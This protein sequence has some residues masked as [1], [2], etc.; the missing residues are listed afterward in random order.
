MRNKGFF[1]FISVLLVSVCL[2]QLSFT[3][4][5]S[6]VEAAAE[7]K[8]DQKVRALRKEAAKN[9]GIAYLSNNT[10]IDFKEADGADLAK[11]AYLNEILRDK[12]EKE[13][14]PV[15]GSTFSQV[16]KRSL[17]FGLDLVGGMSV[18][19]EISLPD[20][21][22]NYAKNPRDLKFR[23]PFEAALRL[24]KEDFLDAFIQEYK[25]INKGLPLNYVFKGEGIGIRSTDA[26]VES[27]FRTLISSS[28]DGVEQIMSRRINQFGVAQPNIQKDGA[29]NRLYIELPGVQDENTVAQKL[30]STAN[31][32]FFETYA[33]SELKLELEKADA[34]SKKVEDQVTEDTT[35]TD[36]VQVESL[37]DTKN[38][39]K[40]G[41]TDLIQPVGDFSIGA[42]QISD[43]AM[44]ESILRRNDVMAAFPPNVRF[45]W[46]AEPE[47][48]DKKSK[49]MGYML[50]ACKVPESGEAKVNG[51][52]ILK[53]STGFDQRDGKITVDLQMTPDGSDAWG[54]MTT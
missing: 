3:W 18:T 50:Y 7:K 38:T 49:K 24:N 9:N 14:Y 35:T 54:K 11:A 37:S 28:M 43:K 30:Q 36:S 20:L 39:G 10:K 47:E 53:A 27:Y 2:Y 13:V 48:L 23:K 46:G 15:F 22:K 45:M 4:V 34:T 1:W 29:N 33:P 41:L 17:A 31:L 5:A 6:N 12:G 40:K 21:I 25:R 52:H 42:V 26:Q 44:V 51:S 19:L 16:K 32:E 8:A